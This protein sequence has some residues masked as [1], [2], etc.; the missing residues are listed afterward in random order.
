MKIWATR[1]GPTLYAIQDISSMSQILDTEGTAQVVAIISYWQVLGKS[2]ESCL[3]NF[4]PHPEVVMNYR[5]VPRCLQH[6][7]EFIPRSLVEYQHLLVE[8]H[9]KKWGVY[10]Y[11]HIYACISRCIVCAYISHV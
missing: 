10:I 1:S 4:R 6:L 9:A 3:L 7:Q 8:N 11:I 2:P 5:S